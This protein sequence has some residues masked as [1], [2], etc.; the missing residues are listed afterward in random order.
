MMTA[1]DPQCPNPGRP[2]ASTLAGARPGGDVAVVGFAGGAAELRERLLA[3]GLIP[4]RTLRVLAQ[5][6]LTLVQVEHTEL[7]LERELA[8]CVEITAR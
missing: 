6:P 8:D 7:A 3:Y 1:H 5:K 4:G 2:A